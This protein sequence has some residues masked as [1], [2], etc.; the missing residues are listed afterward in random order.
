MVL[1]FFEPEEIEALARAADAGAHRGPQPSELDANE[2]AWRKWEDRQDAELYRVAA[3]TGLRLGEL[4]ALFIG[5][6]APSYLVESH[7]SRSEL[8]VG[9]FS[10]RAEVAGGPHARIS[11]GGADTPHAPPCSSPV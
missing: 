3:Y 5:G 9:E 1:D 2:A 7:P 8:R 10:V 11:P 4:L 6:E